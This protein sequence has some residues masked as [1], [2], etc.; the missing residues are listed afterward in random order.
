M[1]K[2]ML[3]IAISFI[4]FGAILFA[5]VMAVLAWDFTQLST[6]SYE[7]NTY[8]V[9]D[10]YTAIVITADTADVVLTA[11]E[12]GKSIVVCHEQTKIKHTVTVRDDTLVIEVA[13]TRKWHEY[14]GIAFGGTRITVEVPSDIYRD[15]S[16]KTSTGDVTVDS[17]SCA[18]DITIEVST[19]KT[20]MSDI[21]CNNLHLSGN[22]GD[23]FLDQVMV[24]QHMSLI[25]STGDIWFDSCDAED[26]YME[27][28]TGDID[29][30]LLSEKVFAVHTDTGKIQIPN[31]V[32]G[33]GCQ[34]ITDTGDIRITIKNKADTALFF[35]VQTAAYRRRVYSQS[36]F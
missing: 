9:V 7:T 26:I 23:V 34:L 32:S 28:D 19:G 5:G 31:T 11:S 15:V 12:T 36:V 30:S 17:L 20:K 13:D 14:I 6:V 4:C 24:A 2:K 3:I 29:G 22:T 35:T 27:T 16:V 18:G 1:S 33:G 10:S 25:R 21:D 8:E